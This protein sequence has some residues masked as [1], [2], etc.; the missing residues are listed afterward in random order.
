M[1][2]CYRSYHAM[3]MVIL[4]TLLIIILCNCVTFGIIVQNPQ[5]SI[6][7]STGTVHFTD[8]NSEDFTSRIEN[9]L[10]NG[11]DLAVS[12]VE[13]IDYQY[14]VKHVAVLIQS[15]VGFTLPMIGLAYSDPIVIFGRHMSASFTENN[16]ITGGHMYTLSREYLS[17]N[18]CVHT[19]EYKNN[20]VNPSLKGGPISLG[21]KELMYQISM[22]L[23]PWNVFA[24]KNYGFHLE[25]QGNFIDM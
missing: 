23:H 8:T 25:W 6:P 4:H 15:M 14:L 16:T 20:R 24:I 12:N 21:D 9:I 3:C 22:C 11:C 5:K 2:F 18:L 1:L 7:F 13:P 10:W 19:A 17:H